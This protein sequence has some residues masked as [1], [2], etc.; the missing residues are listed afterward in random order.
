MVL[1]FAMGLRPLSVKYS[2]R[3]DKIL[4]KEAWKRGK[5]VSLL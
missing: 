1:G 3:F 5:R 2:I 4:G